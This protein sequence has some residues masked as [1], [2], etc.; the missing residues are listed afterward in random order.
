[1]HTYGNTLRKG[2]QGV[3]D[4]IFTARMGWNYG[5]EARFLESSIWKGE[6]LGDNPLLIWKRTLGHRLTSDDSA[7]IHSFIH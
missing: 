6:Q 4:T 3:S 2:I 7:Y 5:T 1:M